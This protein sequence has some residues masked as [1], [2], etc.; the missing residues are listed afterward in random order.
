MPP[1]QPPPRLPSSVFT[2]EVPAR[3]FLGVEK[4]SMQQHD[5]PPDKILR[6]MLPELLPPQQRQ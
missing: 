2:P 3:P 1:P 4:I 6:L 5:V